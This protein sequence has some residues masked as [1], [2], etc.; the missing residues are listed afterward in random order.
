MGQTKRD[1]PAAPEMEIGRPPR[2]S[3]LISLFGE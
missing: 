3:Q 1:G 2:Q